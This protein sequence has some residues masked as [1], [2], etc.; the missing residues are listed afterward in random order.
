MK[1]T[2]F[3]ILAF[4][5]QLSMGGYAQKV[6]L[7]V[8]NVSPQQVFR[9]ITR[10]TGV[11]FVYKE[12]LLEGV[13]PVSIQVKDATI[14]AVLDAC[15]K[16]RQIGYQ[17]VGKSFV[18][19]QIP[20]AAA[21]VAE[22]EI[23]GV[24]RSASG[25]AL[26][27]ISVT[28]KGTSNATHTLNDGSFHLRVSGPDAVLVFTS[29]GFKTV[30]LPL[31]GRTQVEVVLETSSQELSGVVVTALGITRAKRSL[32][33]SVEEV[34][35]KEFTRVNQENILSA[36]SGK[37]A[38]VT[39]N[40]TSGTG[41]SVSIII[42]GATSLSSD[43]QPLFVVDGVPI[44]NTLNNISDVGINN[45]VDYG[46]ALSSINP[47]DIESVT[48]LKGPS[49]AALYGS[50]AGNGVV[51][52]TTKSGRDVRK[53][54]V[55]LTSSTVFDQPYKF[56][57]F[58][59]TF[60]SGAFSAIPVSVSGNPLSNPFGS[61]IQE[62]AHTFGPEL[63]K[64]YTA[65]QW[66]SPLDANGNPIALPLISHPDNVKHFVQTG[67]TSTNGVAI[68][69]SNESSY[70]RLSYANMSNR[71]IIPISDLYLNSLNLNSGLRI[72]KTL[73]LST[74]IDFSRNNSNNRP[75]GERGSNPL[76]AA[77][78]VSPHIDIRDLTSYWLPGEQGIQQRTQYKGAFNNPYF[79]AYEVKNSFVRDR[80]FGNIK[81]DWQMSPAFSL[82][83]RYGLDTYNEKRELK[84]P[85]SYT[86]DPGGGYGIINLNSFENN[87]DFL[88]TYKHAFSHFSLSVSAGGNT[89]YQK[90]ATVR[91]A[92]VDGAG[93]LI[94]PGV[95]TIQNIL[96]N[97][98]SYSSTSYQKGVKSLYGLMNIGYKDMAYLDITGRNDWSSTLP[99]AQPY[100]YPS[101][102]L[103]LL[104]NAIAG[105]HSRAIDMIKLRGG[106]AQVG[107]DAGPYQ[108]L[109]VLSDTGAWSGIP[110]LSTSANLLNQN[111]KPEIATS[112]EGGVDLNMF[113]SR[114]RLAATYYVVENKNQIF[115]TETPPSS[116]YTSRSINAGLL[117][118]RGIELS[119]G[120]TPVLGRDWRWDATANFTR[121]RTTL[122][123][124]Y[125]GLPYFTLWTDAAGGAWTYV[126]DEIGDI[127]D[128]QMVTVTD[129]GSPYYGYPLLDNTGKWQSVSAINAR[130]K[131]GNFNPKF[132]MGFQSSISY[133]QWSLSFTLDWRNGGDFVSQ[134]Y[135][136]GEEFGQSSLFYDHLINPGNKTGQQLHDYLVA[137][138]GKLIR[139]TGNNFPLVGGPTPEYNGYPFTYGPYTL[140]Y[141]G[142]FIP[143]VRAS[144]YDATGHPT[145]YIENLGQNINARN[146]TAIL[147]FAG[148]TA[149][150]FTRAYLFPASYLKLREISV[151]YALPARVVK[152]LKAQNASISVYSR[153][154][155]LWTAAKINI[156]PENAYQPS[157]NVQGNGIQFKQGIERYNVYPWVIPVGFKLNV[158]F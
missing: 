6:T 142:V 25:A 120:G 83:A 10:Q 78:D 14:E 55:S 69:N 70:Y 58:Q 90:G 97:N 119:L 111:L 138:S 149:F 136:Y 153:N 109:A 62:N 15:F 7:V 57:K 100:F 40:S 139:S 59:H 29:V 123:K 110:R 99:N 42:R 150:G 50:R 104:V 141:G 146:G 67:I 9:E 154:I 17:L 147:P 143:G 88:L 3:C 148:A 80:V 129:K 156:D 56:L 94:V 66:N 103:S 48:V 24:V 53:M 28:E 52:I 152:V 133:K 47:D 95:F 11:S 4:C 96:P 16:G 91:T 93:G 158:I 44:A 121:S 128:A 51:L 132:I 106:V 35:G 49:A 20:P 112:Y 31:A 72:Y 131:I 85:E 126:G 65:V 34:G 63:N 2:A 39:I 33:Y 107:N 26:E 137:N 18:I 105:I 135:R 87:A 125:S 46:N 74:S 19:R 12:S 116:G 84:I 21:P 36:M 127:Y 98:L 115:S 108:L 140:P 22:L 144:G 102:S 45:R 5:L 43:N 71:G 86:D 77:Y 155:I 82:M 8:K 118:S 124:L 130:N 38:G 157:T 73:R 37:V 76:E 41:S 101:A 145:G 151:A 1:L 113:Q 68:A 75:A 27:G 61:L 60:G 54:T 117:R 32:G 81:A 122:V 89:R 13:A 30:E 79:L 23:N 134:T 92:T 114:L 64:G